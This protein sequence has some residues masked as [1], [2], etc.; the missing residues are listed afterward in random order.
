[1]IGISDSGSGIPPEIRSRIFDPFF[2]T[3][4]P[5]RGTGLGLSQA[6]GIVTEHQG[7]ITVE[8]H[9]GQG[10]QFTLS[11]PRLTEDGAAAPVER[12]LELVTGAGQMVL[13]VEDEAP[14]RQTLAAILADLN[15]QTLTASSAENALELHAAHAGQVALVLTDLV[16][17]GLG[18]LGLVRAFR[19][20]DVRVPIVMMSGYVADSTRTP[21][22]GVRAWV[23]KPVSA[24]R[25]GLVIQEALA[26]G[27]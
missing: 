7:H 13:V 5:G 12:G 4:A 3:K 27:A 14:V 17:P 25:L 20:R 15:Y 19:E 2:T 26:P 11:L 24:H 23:E 22:D 16:M 21:V 18:G 8:S 6:Y 10:T 1:V 9:P